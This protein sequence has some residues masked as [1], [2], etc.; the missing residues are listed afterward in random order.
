MPYE[1]VPTSEELPLLGLMINPSSTRSKRGY[2]T[3]YMIFVPSTRSIAWELRA[4]TFIQESTKEKLGEAYNQID[5][6]EKEAFLVL[7]NLYFFNHSR[8]IQVDFS[9][10]F[11][12]GEVLDFD[13]VFTTRVA[14]TKEGVYLAQEPGMDM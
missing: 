2:V 6:L 12:N 3:N 9:E 10:S 4:Q 8:E 7:S 1:V 14:S 13:D 5:S 11:P